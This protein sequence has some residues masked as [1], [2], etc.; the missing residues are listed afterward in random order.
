[1]PYAPPYLKF[2]PPGFGV[3]QSK[4][5]TL[6][7][8]RWGSG[9]YMY[10]FVSIAQSISSLLLQTLRVFKDDSLY[11]KSLL[12]KGIDDDRCA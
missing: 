8:K 6:P 7:Y 4:T 3:S 12:I 10:H 1:M 9:G 11:F 5:R 2:S